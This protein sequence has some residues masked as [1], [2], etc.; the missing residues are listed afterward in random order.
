MEWNALASQN[1]WWGDSKEI[2]SDREVRE[3]LG[4]RKKYIS[5]FIRGN[6]LI[7]GPR[8]TGKTTYMKL[9]IRE[10]IKRG[11]PAKQCLYF[12]CNLVMKPQDIIDIAEMFKKSGGK[13][14]FFDEISF[15]PEWERAVKHI[16]EVKSLSGGM[17]FYFTGSATLELQKERFPGRNVRIREFLPLGFREF[18]ELFGSAELKQSL[19]GKAALENIADAAPRLMAFIGE[20]SALFDKYVHCGGFLRAA[21]ELI[22]EGRIQ[23]ETYQTYWNWIAGDIARLG[24][25]E[26]TLSAILKGVVKRY[27]TPFSLSAIAKEA[28]V[29]S[30]ITAR[31]YLEVLESLLVL[32]SYWKGYDKSPVFRKERKAYFIDPFLYHLASFKT[33]GEKEEREEETPKIVEGIVGEAFRRLN[34]EV[35]FVR[36]KKEVDFV[37]KGT[38]IEVKWKKTVTESDFPDIPVRKKI[39]LSKNALSSG[40]GVDIIPVPVFLLLL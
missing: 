6:Y 15:V 12:V 14:A 4:K 36:K 22:G 37:L 28:E 30:H 35:K 1:P 9:C 8:Q 34:M 38:G 11:I 16:L 29:P 32:R 26:R 23:D 19:P 33:L 7:F 25:S 5:P 24:L 40:K 21:Y 20:I 10:L 13:Y 3:A 27:S 18:A 31:D 39:L 2:E 17:N